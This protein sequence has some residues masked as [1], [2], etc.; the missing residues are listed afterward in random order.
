MIKN[1]AFILIT[2]FYALSVIAGSTGYVYEGK[3]YY[4]FKDGKEV[5]ESPLGENSRSPASI[6]TNKKN[7][8]TMILYFTEDN[9][10][11]CYFW[12]KKYRKNK[13]H[14]KDS[15]IHCLKLSDLK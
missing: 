15:N 8:N 13:K 14:Q 2:S 12:D 1:T 5:N 9:L 3:T 4:I 6:N 10:V 7:N 11:R